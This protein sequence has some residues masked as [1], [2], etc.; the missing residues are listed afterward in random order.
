M[1][2]RDGVIVKCLDGWLRDALSRELPVGELRKCAAKIVAMDGDITAAWN[3]GKCLGVI[4]AAELREFA[5]ALTT[6]VAILDDLEA[7][8]HQ[9]R[10][11]PTP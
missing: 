11:R 6:T 1:I 2:D 9:E 3:E 4:A 5:N 7:R 8:K 10:M